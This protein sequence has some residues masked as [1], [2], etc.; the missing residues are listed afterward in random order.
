MESGFQKKSFQIVQFL[1]QLTILSLSYHHYH[2]NTTANAQLLV[3]DLTRSDLRRPFRSSQE[4]QQ[5]NLLGV[6]SGSKVTNSA[7]S[8][9]VAE[10]VSIATRPNNKRTIT[11]FIV[12][13]ESRTH[14]M[15][16][17]FPIFPFLLLIKPI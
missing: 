6:D 2:G 11:I 8:Y 3:T 14:S 13:S 9:L 17:V 5:N 12:I 16:R 4:T 10:S 15:S 7:S 1:L